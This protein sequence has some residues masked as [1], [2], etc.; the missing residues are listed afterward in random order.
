M[1]LVAGPPRK[2][3]AVLPSPHDQWHLGRCHFGDAADGSASTIHRVPPC[4]RSAPASLELEGKS[5][6][7]AT[8]TARPESV[9]W[10]QF[11]PEFEDM[12]LPDDPASGHAH[13]CRR[14]SRTKLTP[15]MML[16]AP[17]TPCE[18]PFAGSARFEAPVKNRLVNVAHA[19]HAP[20]IPR[21]RLHCTRPVASHGPK[22]PLSCFNSM[23]LAP[24][25]CALGPLVSTNLSQIS[26]DYAEPGS[27]L[28]LVM[29][30]DTVRARPASRRR[31][32][33]P[34]ACPVSRDRGRS[35]AFCV[36]EPTARIGS[37]A[38]TQ[39]GLSLQ[40][41]CPRPGG[42]QADSPEF[43]RALGA[44][45]E[46]TRSD[47]RPSEREVPE[48]PLCTFLLNPSI[49]IV[50]TVYKTSGCCPSLTHRPPPPNIR[51]PRHVSGA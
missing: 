39:V 48:T 29:V 1:Y 15:P 26:S 12:T 41:A 7:A 5:A 51:S 20:L 22:R 34:C 17:P 11:H 28:H 30:T 43:L 9:S 42:T 36:T 35:C 2:L 24:R 13:T 3:R 10:A 38:L 16:L 25:P 4:P 27:F 40:T 37:M 45:P 18:P 44:R 14:Q 23:H 6:G 47:H 19:L 32:Y 8:R 50:H 33:R 21:A 31:S 49:G 46:S